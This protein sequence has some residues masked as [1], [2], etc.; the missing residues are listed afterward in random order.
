MTAASALAVG[1][2]IAV[3]VLQVARDARR[4]AKARREY[5]STAPY[6]VGEEPLELRPAPR[7]D[8]PPLDP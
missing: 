3:S 4:W 8:Q 1:L 5:R 2:L 7:C 6:V